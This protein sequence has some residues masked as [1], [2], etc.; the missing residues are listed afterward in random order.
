MG[1]NSLKLV[2]EMKRVLVFLFF[3]KYC[4]L[5]LETA[6]INPHTGAHT[7]PVNGFAR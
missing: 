7:E 4:F 5:N 3:Y 1:L 2:F 6:L